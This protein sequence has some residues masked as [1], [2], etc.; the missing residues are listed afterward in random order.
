[1][2]PQPERAKN[3]TGDAGDN[4]IGRGVIASANSHWRKR[5]RTIPPISS[6]TLPLVMSSPCS[7]R[8]PHVL[9]SVTSVDVDSTVVS[10]VPGRADGYV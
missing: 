9:L 7:V 1:V 4:K 8:R 2:T 10:S 6:V 5:R 3:S